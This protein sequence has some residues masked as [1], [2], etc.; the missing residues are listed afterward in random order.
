[1]PANHLM[2]S[3]TYCQNRLLIQ[4]R[5]GL[6]TVMYARRQPSLVQNRTFTD[7]F[8]YQTQWFWV[9]ILKPF[10][11]KM[12]INKESMQEKTSAYRFKSSTLHSTMSRKPLPSWELYLAEG[13]V[14]SFCRR[15]NSFQVTFSLL[16]TTVKKWLLLI[17]QW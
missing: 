6:Q 16:G 15:K 10:S 14:S 13:C 17:F 9:V 12:C 8:F 7:W 5:L 3:N 2:N 1:M 4:C 11:Y